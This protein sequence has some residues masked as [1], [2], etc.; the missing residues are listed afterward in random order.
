MKEMDKCVI[1]TDTDKAVDWIRNNKNTDVGD[2]PLW[3]L[4][5]L[6]LKALREV[7]E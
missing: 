4:I 2:T 5:G 3:V 6:G 1:Y 7:E